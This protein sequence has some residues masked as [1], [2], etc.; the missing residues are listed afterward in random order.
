MKLIIVGTSAMLILAETAFAIPAPTREAMDFNSLERRNPTPEM[1]LTEREYAEI[2]HKL[3]RH[4]F[5]PEAVVDIKTGDEEVKVQLQRRGTDVKPHSN[6][7]MEEVK[8][9]FSAIVGGLRGI[10]LLSS[11]NPEKQHKTDSSDDDGKD[12]HT[13]E[14]TEE[15]LAKKHPDVTTTVGHK[16]VVVTKTV[17]TTKTGGDAPATT[18]AATHNEATK[19]EVKDTSAG[20]AA[21]GAP[22]VP[23]PT[24]A[25]APAAA[26]APPA[27]AAAP[28]PAPAAAP[29]VSRRALADELVAA[30]ATE[31]LVERRSMDPV[32]NSAYEAAAAYKKIARRQLSGVED[33]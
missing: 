1:R 20:A 32:Y 17:E 3:S 4:R 33:F 9:F 14:L 10:V 2:E 13:H 6:N 18:D 22:A 11:S 27:E 8:D 16:I 29:V 28:A 23:A 12:R 25:A 30:Y 7:F 19:P 21:P 5:N 31:G 15:D 26:A 24:G